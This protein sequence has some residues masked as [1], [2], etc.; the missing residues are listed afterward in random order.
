[1]TFE[2]YHAHM[3]EMR[4]AK[5]NYIVEGEPVAEQEETEETKAM[6]A[7]LAKMSEEERKEADKMSYLMLKAI[8]SDREDKRLAME[9]QIAAEIAEA[10]KNIKAKY[11]EQ[12]NAEFA[13]DAYTKH[14]KEMIK[15][16]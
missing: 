3:E 12:T 7:A 10:E 5:P 15:K 4:K 14:L 9:A 2:E 8:E 1:M 13:E 16:L 6:K 11:A